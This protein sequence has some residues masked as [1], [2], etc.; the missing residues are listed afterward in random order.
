[1]KIPT[2]PR[3]LSDEARKW[4]KA[5]CTEYDITDEGGKLLLQTGLEAF[6]RM[7]AAQAEITKSGQIQTDRFGQQKEHQLLSVERDAMAQMIAALKS[8]NL[9]I[10]PLKAGP[11]RPPGR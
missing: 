8:L 7:R 9:D 4:W 11:G 2:A 10:E 5:L 1:M 3:H 6:D